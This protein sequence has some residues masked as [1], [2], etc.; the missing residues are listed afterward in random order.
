MKKIAK[1]KERN[2]RKKKKFV[3]DVLYIFCSIMY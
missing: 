2:R 3:V 1:E